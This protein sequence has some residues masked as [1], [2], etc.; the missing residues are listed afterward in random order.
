MCDGTR[1]GRRSSTSSGRCATR[2]S[3]RR[4]RVPRREAWS[5]TPKLMKI[6]TRRDTIMLGPGVNEIT[7]EEFALGEAEHQAR[8]EDWPHPGAPLSGFRRSRRMG[9]RPRRS[10]TSR[11]TTLSP[12]SSRSDPH[13]SRRSSRTTETATP[14]TAGLLRRP[15]RTSP[16]RSSHACASSVSCRR[17]TR[18]HK[19][20][21]PKDLAVARAL[22]AEEGLGRAD[23]RRLRRGRR[24]RPDGVATRERRP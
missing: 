10:P 18:E 12:W 1:R 24:A 7:R 11:S 17:A 5:R 16:L 6:K 22:V 9:K 4:R 2:P 13:R 15:A 21:D 8:A 3:S 19:K 14:S 23:R 20:P